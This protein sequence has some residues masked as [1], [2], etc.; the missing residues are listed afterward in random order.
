MQIYFSIVGLVD[1]STIFTLFWFANALFMFIG[2]GLPMGLVVKFSG[3][4]TPQ[5]A[6]RAVLAIGHC[7]SCAYRIFDIEAE[8]DGCT[9]CPECGGA[10]KIQE[11]MN[12]A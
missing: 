12:S 6:K 10:W 4:R 5:R 9:V 2:F 1:R 3:W 8:P 11:A 7:P